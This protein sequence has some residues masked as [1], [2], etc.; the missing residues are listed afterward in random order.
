MKILFAG[1]PESAAIVLRNLV[2]AGHDVVAVLTRDDAA[3]GR[4][5]VLTESPVATEAAAHGIRVIKAN[6]VDSTTI[7]KIRFTGAELGIVV[8]YGSILSEKA[9]AALQQGWLNLHYSLLPNYRGAAPVQWS[10]ANGDK[11]TGITV[12]KIDKGMDTG[13]IL[14]TLPVLVQPDET[15]G[16]LIHR[17]SELGSTLLIECL[18]RLYTGNYQLAEQ[19]GEVSLAPKPTREDARIDF[20]LTATEI[21]NLVKAMN[22]E[23][24]AWCLL[25]GQPFR[26]L[27]ARAT[28][29]PGFINA[30]GSIVAGKNPL[31]ACGDGTYLEL[32]EVQ[33]SSKKAMAAAD[34][35]RGSANA[36]V[37][38]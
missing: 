20:N 8:A 6:K 38:R 5:R 12:F 3:I 1:T 28:E 21:E 32:I 36:E 19:V 30:I 37:L 10:L 15:A 24:M 9:L 33:P 31:V 17:L 29:L 25:D 26:I 4:K 13:P 16:E 23:P 2:R 18:P 7:D 22:P 14:T 34:W 27:R 11:E 35:F